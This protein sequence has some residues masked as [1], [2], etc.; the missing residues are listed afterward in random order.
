MLFYLTALLLVSLAHTREYD[1]CYH[2]PDTEPTCMKVQVDSVNQTIHYHMPGSD[3][4]EEIDTLEDYDMGFAATRVEAQE[5]CFLRALP[6]S[7]SQEVQYVE[8]HQNITSVVE[9][10]QDVNAVPVDNPE[11]EVGKRLADFCGDLP[12]YKLVASEDDDN[13]VESRQV[14]V[15]YRRCILFFLCWLRCYTTTLTIPTG[16]SITFFWFFG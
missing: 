15:T 7:F 11:T 6:M 12:V 14:S 16:S 3:N 8:E 2:V 5:S 4:F 1:M 10:N 13:S 9:G